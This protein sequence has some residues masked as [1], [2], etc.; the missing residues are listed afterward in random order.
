MFAR[1]ISKEGNAIPN[2]VFKARVRDEKIISDN[3]FDWKDV[4]TDDLFKG[5]RAVIFC[6]PGAFTPTCSSTHLPGY[7]KNYEA[8]KAAGVD[9]VYCLS[10][11]DAF[12]MRQWGIYQKL[13][14]ENFN[15]SNPLNPGNFKKVKLIPDGAALFTRGMGMSTVWDSE[16]GFGERS[17]RYSVVINDNKVEKLFVEGSGPVQNHGPDPFEVSDADTM[18]AYLQSN[19]KK[20]KADAT[21]EKEEK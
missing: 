19:G 6:L 10:V 9:E 14:A 3:P 11:N 20:R 17:W 16:R 7:E 4:S 15:E 1:A 8:I 2:V 21:V 5:K 18:L 12:V 13:D